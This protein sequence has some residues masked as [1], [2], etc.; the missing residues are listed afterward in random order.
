M[1]A[2][3]VGGTHGKNHLEVLDIEGRM[4]MIWLLNKV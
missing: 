3:V 4:V 1:N 2:I